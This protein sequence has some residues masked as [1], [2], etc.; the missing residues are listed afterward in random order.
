MDKLLNSKTLTPNFLA[1]PNHTYEKLRPLETS[2]SLK[3]FF[4]MVREEETFTP[5]VKQTPSFIL[6]D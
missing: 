6:R 3:P 5:D 1:K 4:R 2:G